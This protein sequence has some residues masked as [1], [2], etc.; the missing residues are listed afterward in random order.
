MARRALRSHCSFSLGQHAPAP[1]SGV[2][3]SNL[4]DFAGI[5]EIAWDVVLEEPKKMKPAT[6]GPAY[7][8]IAEVVVWE[9]VQRAL[10][11]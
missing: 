1:S 4:P 9:E 3:Y 11:S 7:L 6:D 10:L 5:C 8:F 2:Q